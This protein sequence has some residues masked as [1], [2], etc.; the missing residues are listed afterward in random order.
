MFRMNVSKQCHVQDDRAR[1][2]ST[3]AAGG[4]GALPEKDIPTKRSRG[5][6]RLACDQCGKSREDGVQLQM[7]SGCGTAKGGAVYCG[8]E[9]Q[10]RHW[11][12]H[13]AECIKM[14]REL[15]SEKEEVS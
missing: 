6:R 4:E 14:Q 12:K 5:K 15:Q 3:G 9:C 11:P 13:K 10:R 8:R 7:C 1:G 2:V